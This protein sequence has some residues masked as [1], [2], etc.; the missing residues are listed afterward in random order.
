MGTG[1]GTFGE[2]AATT[3]GVP[4]LDP[5]AERHTSTPPSAELDE[6]ELVRRAQLGSSAAFEQLVVTR[7]PSLYRYLAVRLPGEG[8]ARDA[9]QET[10][11][12]A[13]QGLPSLKSGGKFWPWLCGIAA[14]KAADIARG[15]SHAALHEVDARAPEDDEIL[16]VRDAVA[17]LPE[18]FRQVLLLRHLLGLSEAEVAE[19]LGTRVGTVKSRSARARKALEDLLR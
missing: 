7:G 2:V 14:H 12:A 15:R 16:A 11:L 5:S 1:N 18:P 9:L 8:D 3:E 13:W 19:V 6:A 17:A 4:G 10:L